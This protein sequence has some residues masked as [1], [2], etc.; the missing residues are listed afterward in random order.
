MSFSSFW[1][2]AGRRSVVGCSF[3]GTAYGSHQQVSNKSKG[4]YSPLQAKA[5]S[6]GSGRLRLPDLFDTRH[7]EGGK[8]VNFTHRPPSL[9]SN[10]LVLIFRGSVK[11]PGIDPWTHRLVAQRLNH[12]TSPDPH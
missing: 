3:L 4:K 2:V 5:A 7:Y 1:K 10:I 12:Y 9:S 8:V 11:P 6:W